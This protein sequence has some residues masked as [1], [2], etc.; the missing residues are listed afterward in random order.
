MSPYLKKKKSCE[1]C[2]TSLGLLLVCSMHP[3]LPV[4]THLS[5]QY[6][7][8]LSKLGSAL[9]V[10]CAPSSS[11]T[12]MSV[13]S[14]HSSS[15]SAHTSVCSVHS[16]SPSTHTPQ[17]AVCTPALP[18]H[19]HLSVQHAP[20]SPSAHS[21]CSVH[22]ALPAL[23]HLFHFCVSNWKTTDGVA[24]MYF[25]ALQ[26]DNNVPVLLSVLRWPILITLSLQRE[27][28]AFSHNRIKT[29]IWLLKRCM[30]WCA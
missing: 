10:Q 1:K 22:P 4:R 12:H 28:V 11:S 26:C 21:V 7:P 8:R 2:F 16:S 25:C 3:A 20:G 30:G 19:T 6:A 17:C 15:P 29:Q 9:S 18:A 5:V 13:S 24:G 27:K 23:T 14:M